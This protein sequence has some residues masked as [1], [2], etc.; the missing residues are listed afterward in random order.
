VPFAIAKTEAQAHKR[1]PFSFERADGQSRWWVGQGRRTIER[2]HVYEGCYTSNA[3]KTEMHLTRIQSRKAAPASLARDRV[4]I[5]TLAAPAN[6]ADGKALTSSPKYAAVI[7][8]AKAA[9]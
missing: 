5:V 9:D 4:P 3:K 2:L 1:Q 8:G 7:S 6:I